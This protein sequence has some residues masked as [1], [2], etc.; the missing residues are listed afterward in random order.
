MF[1][2]YFER[3]ITLLFLLLIVGNVSCQTESARELPE[4]DMLQ[5][6]E[7]QCTYS[8][9]ILIAETYSQ[10]VDTLVAKLLSGGRHDNAHLVIYK[11]RYLMELY[12]DTV[13]IKRYPIALG[14]N[15]V[16]DKVRQG[17]QCTP[18]G[19]FY[20]CRLVNPSQYYKA[21]LISYPNKEDAERG[22]KDGLITKA[23]QDAII[24][25]ISKGNTPPQNTSLGS[26][27]EIHGEGVGYNWTLGCVAMENKDIDELWKLVRI[28]TPVRIKK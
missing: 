2:L 9:S 1:I 14:S 24:S 26:L 10:T 21:F 15:P 18:E 28:G 6:T 4:V 12:S 23:Q 13:L 5:V 3:F 16:D 25:A 11:S 27:I 8:D 20:V 19:D 17:D 7:W 22:L